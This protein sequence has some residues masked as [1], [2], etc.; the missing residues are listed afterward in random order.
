[1]KNILLVVVCAF[2]IFKISAQQDPQFTQNMFNRLAV[3]PAYAGAKE[4]FCATLISRQQWLGFE[5]NPKT[6]LFSADYGFKIQGRHQVGAGL[7]FIQDEIGPIQSLNAKLSMAYHYRIAQGV[8]AGG[9]EVGIFN[10]SING[11]WRTSEGNFDGT[12]DPKIPNSEAG[13]TAL[14]I[15]AGL[16]YYTKELYVGISSTHL[17]QPEISDKP[18]ATS[19]LTFQQVRHYYVM[20]GYNYLTAAGGR[21]LELQPSIF[22]KTDAVSTQV[23]V[24]F[25]AKYN[26]LIWAGVSY[27]VQDAVSLLAGID[28]GGLKLGSQLDNIRV[29]FAYDY[30]VSDLSSY[31][32]GSIE[33]MLNYCY[34]FIKNEKLERYKSVRFL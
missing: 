21:D 8:L 2:S 6:N 3:N 26:N 19:S 18:D 33:F 4:S 20:G 25:N 12:E 27:R 5:G 22:A 13:A 16:Y 30:N 7:T 9:L 23:D 34:K 15:G 29:G 32:N 10:Q 31:N 11:K 24:N 1:M 14:D 17:N 28:L